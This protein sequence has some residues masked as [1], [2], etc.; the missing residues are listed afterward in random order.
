MSDPSIFGS[1]KW[2]KWSDNVRSPTVISSTVIQ[3]NTIRYVL[4][5][6]KLDVCVLSEGSNSG[7]LTGIHHM[8][9]LLWKCAMCCE[10]EKEMSTFSICKI[11]R[12]K[13]KNLT[14]HTVKYPGN[15]NRYTSTSITK[16]L[17]SQ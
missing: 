15:V 17:Y 16:I 12:S 10:F 14:M 13:C 9:V 2:P 4:D 11:L 7:G 8:G 1:D 6:G 3:Y 5:N